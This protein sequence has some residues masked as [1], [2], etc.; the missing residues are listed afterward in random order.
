M[1]VLAVVPGPEG[2]GVVRHGVTVAHLVGAT[3][4]RDLDLPDGP[5]D[6]VHVQF[7]DALFG[8]S[9]E[10]AALAFREWAATVHAPVVVTVHDVPGAD[11]D[12]GRDERRRAGYRTVAAAAD[13]VVVCSEHEADRLHPRPAVVALPL[14]RLCPPGPE[15]AWADRPSV[16]VLGFVYPGKGHD[17]VLRATAGTG[18]LVVAVGGPS[19]GHEGLVTDL[20]ARADALD[21]ELLVTGPLTEADLHAAALAVTVPVAAY[22]TTGASASLLTWLAA[23]RRPVT[24]AGPYAAELARQRPGSLL[25]TDDLPGAVRTAL[26][27]PGS[28]RAACSPDRPDVA[29]ALRAVYARTCR[30]A[31]QP[32]SR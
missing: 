22:A 27:D 23:G 4:S 14:D 18:A 26:A 16:G 25:P 10:S 12:A 11:H 19:P 7:T 29:A 32:V 9:I 5:W 2:H 20:R 6:L 30:S 15:P 8:S 28:T 21:V 3:V 1:R 24:T 31:G 17:P 13:A